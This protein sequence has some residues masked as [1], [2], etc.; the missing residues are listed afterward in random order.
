MVGRSPRP[1]RARGHSAWHLAALADASTATA[2]FR[3]RIAGA[4]NQS[5]RF[6]DEGL[7]N[8]VG[9]EAVQPSLPDFADLPGARFGSY[10]G[11]D[12]GL[13]ALNLISGQ[14]AAGQELSH[15]FFHDRGQEMQLSSFRR[16]FFAVDLH[17]CLPGLAALFERSA[18]PRARTLRKS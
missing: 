1:C 18:D 14:D 13:D 16:L 3:P 12:G 10:A 6:G 4:E 11:T 15:Q 9:R 7:G 2:L 17:P 8:G 5:V